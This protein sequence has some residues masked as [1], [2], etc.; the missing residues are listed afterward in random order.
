MC[1]SSPELCHL[2]F[3]KGGFGRGYILIWY[4]RGGLGGNSCWSCL[5]WNLR[6]PLYQRYLCWRAA[7]QIEAVW[8]KRT[9]LIV[10]T[11]VCVYSPFRC[12]C[13][14]YWFVRGGWWWLLLFLDGQLHQFLFKQN[15]QVASA[16]AT[17]QED[18]DTLH[19]IFYHHNTFT[20]SS[21]AL[22][23]LVTDATFSLSS[24]SM[25]SSITWSAQR[26]RLA[27]LWYTR[28]WQEDSAEL[29]K[30]CENRVSQELGGKKKDCCGLR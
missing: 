20:P 19:N 2:S 23:T 18:W 17:L 3:R 28:L 10:L 29:L 8:M 1:T 13:R 22:M 15:K 25:P 6:L 24:K 12:C 26:M 4:V 7:T 5:I 11:D 27:R 21:T 30:G 14:G 9:A 16:S